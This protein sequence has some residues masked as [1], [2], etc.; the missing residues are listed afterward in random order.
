M[1]HAAEQ[2]SPM[3]TTLLTLTPVAFV[4]LWSTGFI[5]AKLGL[6]HASPLAFLS[7]RFALV[8]AIL[9]PLAFVLRRPWPRDPILAAHLAVAGILLHGGYLSGVFGAIHAGMSAGIIALI[10][11]LQPLL[12]AL[13]GGAMVGERVS[14]RRWL[15]LVAGFLGVVLVVSGKTDGAEIDPRAAV[16]AVMALVSI[17]LGTLYQKRFCPSFDLWTGSA[18]QFAAAAGVLVPLA[19]AFDDWHIDWN[20]EFVFALGW[21]VLVLSIGAISL[22]HVLIRR[23][24]ATRVSALFYL[25]PPTTALMAFA[26]FGERLSSLAL[27]GMIIVAVG[28]WLGVKR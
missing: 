27:V 18:F 11:G 12:T 9:I 2:N 5:G 20:G 10:V 1:P 24:E 16:L 3:Q 23:G 26:I 8:L 4:V 25:T 22:L 19:F 7:I 17:T 6:P 13:L 28:V 15:G 21:L 14:A